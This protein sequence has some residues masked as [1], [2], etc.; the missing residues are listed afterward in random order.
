MSSSH[1]PKGRSAPAQTDPPWSFSYETSFPAYA[2]LLAS[3]ASRL[4]GLLIPFKGMI[5]V[6]TM[7]GWITNSIV[8]QLEEGV[9]IEKAKGVSFRAHCRMLREC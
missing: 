1:G 9:F 7:F 6:G 8:N 3:G 2:V 4:A 5:Y